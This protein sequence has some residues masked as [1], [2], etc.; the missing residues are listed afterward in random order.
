M[1]KK[2]Q[3]RTVTNLSEGWRANFYIEVAVLLHREKPQISLWDTRMNL[4]FYT[5]LWCVFTR[6][7]PLVPAWDVWNFG[8]WQ[9]LPDPLGRYPSSTEWETKVRL[10]M[11]QADYQREGFS[12]SRGKTH[13]FCSRPETN[14]LA[15]FKRL[16][17][18]ICK[19]GII[20]IPA[21]QA[22]GKN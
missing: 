22:H 14:F 1:F 2:L 9:G 19:M 5:F 20:I 18:L 12:R 13:K 17:F 11:W 10:L 7:T 16:C 4:K 3:A 6:P 8:V 15:S 21:I